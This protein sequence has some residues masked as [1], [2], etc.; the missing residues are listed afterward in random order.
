[1]EKNAP[2]QNPR[3]PFK[4]IA[5]K[6]LT[7]WRH[8]KNDQPLNRQN[9]P[10]RFTLFSHIAPSPAITKIQSPKFRRETLRPLV[11]DSLVSTVMPI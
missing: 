8:P 5:P 1:M 2:S 7:E 11:M 9:F 10:S 6:I 4:T 3:I